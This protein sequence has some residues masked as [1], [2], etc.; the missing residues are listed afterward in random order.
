MVSFRG[1]ED[2]DD[3]EARGGGRRKKVA[4]EQ[5]E[6]N[7]RDSSSRIGRSTRGEG[8]GTEFWRRRSG[9]WRYNVNGKN[10]IDRGTP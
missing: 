8:S 7:T 10:A 2:S 4:Q 1:A 3:E 5:E 6:S 9:I